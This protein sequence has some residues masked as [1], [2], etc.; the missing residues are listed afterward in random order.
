MQHAQ[1]DHRDGRRQ[2]PEQDDLGQVGQPQLAVGEDGV[3]SEDARQPERE[4]ATLQ[5]GADP[6]RERVVEELGVAFVEGRAAEQAVAVEHERAGGEHAHR[7][8]V[9]V[10]AA[11]HTARA[12]ARTDNPKGS[13]TRRGMANASTATALWS[14][15]L[16]GSGGCHRSGSPALLSS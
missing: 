5:L 3:A 8:Q 14:S 15:R 6:L 10:E 13:G 2:R 1:P 12:S 4:G 11:C 7:D 16:S 9:Q